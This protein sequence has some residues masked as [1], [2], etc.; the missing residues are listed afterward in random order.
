M[1]HAIRDLGLSLAC[2][3]LTEAI[4]EGITVL[5]L[6]LAEIISKDDFCDKKTWRGTFDKEHTGQSANAW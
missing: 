5:C 3:V 2:V 6:E 4:C 1:Y